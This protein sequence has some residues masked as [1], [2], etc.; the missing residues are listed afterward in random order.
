MKEVGRDE[1]SH[2]FQFCKDVSCAALG[3]NLLS[4]NGGIERTK[5]RS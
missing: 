2:I 3:F 5:I 1:I 4:K